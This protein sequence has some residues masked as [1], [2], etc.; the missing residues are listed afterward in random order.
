MIVLDASA[1]LAFLRR[2]VGHEVVNA[3]LGQACI[4]AINF[5][6]ALAR[7]S[8]FGFAPR[9]LRVQLDSTGLQVIDFDVA[10]SIVVAEIREPMRKAGIGIADCCC[11]A[12]GLHLALPVLTADR[13]WTALDLGVTVQLIR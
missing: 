10:Q 9:D 6:E 2:E 4:S 3:Q 7:M 11:L 13:A 5:A 1:L 8:T 12:L